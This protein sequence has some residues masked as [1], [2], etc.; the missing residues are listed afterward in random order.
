MK[1]TAIVGKTAC[2]AYKSDTF[3]ACVCVAQCISYRFYKC[4]RALWVHGFR[5]QCTTFVFGAQN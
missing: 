2:I 4:R 1:L 3:V 5:A